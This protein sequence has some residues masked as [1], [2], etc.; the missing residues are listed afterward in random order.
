MLSPRLA[1]LRFDRLAISGFPAPRARAVAALGDPL[2]VDLRYDLAVAG[3]QRLGRA[4]L[5]TQRQLAFRQAIGAVFLELVPGAVG[6]RPAGAIRAFVHF[7]ARAEIT[8]L[9]VLRRAEWAGVEAIA[10]A[11]AEVFRMQHHA[12]GRGVEAVHRTHRLA[13]RVGAMHASHGDRA[14]ARLAV[15][16][17]HHAAAVDAPRHLVLVFAGGDAGV[18][19][20]ATVGIAEKFHPSHCRASL[21][22]L[23][24]A[25]RGFGFL[26]AG[27]GIEPVGGDRVHALAEHDRIAALRILEALVVILEPAREMEGHPGHSLAD[28]LGDER[29]HPGHLAALHLGA[30]DIHPGPVLDAALGGVRG[31]DL[32]EHVLLELGEPFVGARLLAA[33]LE[34]DQAAGRED[35]G[36]N[37]GDALVH[38]GLLHREADIGHAELLG[39]R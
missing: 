15:I 29:L 39:V 32:D 11:N 33:A 3:K 8:N 27:D 26:H 25:Q 24:L 20:D 36:E 34:L 13:W 38:R 37:L 6:F 7:S 28:A 10:A 4:H 17:G 23:D 18:A 1:E 16:D 21:R 35:E 5:R 31:I 9:G 14:L 19:L 2:L 12:V 30:P 22:R